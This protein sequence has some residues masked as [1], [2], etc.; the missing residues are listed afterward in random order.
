MRL[1]HEGSHLEVDNV[2]GQ[3]SLN[4]DGWFARAGEAEQVKWAVGGCSILKN[5]IFRVLPSRL[6]KP[7]SMNSKLFNESFTMGSC[8]CWTFKS[9]G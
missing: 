7:E 5:K 6:N 9:P 2:S 3:C 4:A 8:L 1:P